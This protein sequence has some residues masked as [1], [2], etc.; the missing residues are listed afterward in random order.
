MIRQS[1]GQKG[2][3]RFKLHD[4]I[5]KLGKDHLE[6]VALDSED[7]LASHEKVI[8]DLRAAVLQ[9]PTWTSV[10]LPSNWEALRSLIKVAR[11]SESTLIAQMHV[12]KSIRSK[13]LASAKKKRAA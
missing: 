7:V 11:I 2:S 12:L 1:W 4:I 9:M 5:E 10:S 13:E 3:T 8:D 6:V